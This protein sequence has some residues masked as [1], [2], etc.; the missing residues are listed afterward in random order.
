[1]KISRTSIK[2]RFEVRAAV[3]EIAIFYGANFGFGSFK[4]NG[5]EKS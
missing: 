3:L 2:L 5:V 4:R 1:M